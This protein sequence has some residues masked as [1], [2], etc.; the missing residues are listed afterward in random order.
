MDPTQPNQIHLANHIREIKWHPG[1]AVGG[2][3]TVL[4]GL[5]P[6]PGDPPQQWKWWD[7]DLLLVVVDLYST[8][9]IR[10]VRVSAD[11]DHLAFLDPHTQDDDF[12][13]GSEDIAWW[14]KLGPDSFPPDRRRQPHNVGIGSPHIG[15]L[16]IH[17]NNQND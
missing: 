13:Y 5:W 14:A 3:G 2:T 12:G 15:P 17:T 11:G 7:G 10:M 8:R 1:P 4:P 9:E 16:D 6:Q